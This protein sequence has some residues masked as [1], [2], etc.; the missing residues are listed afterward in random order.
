MPAEDPGLKVQ[1]G[2]PRSALDRNVDFL[3][4]TCKEQTFTGEETK[5]QRNTEADSGAGPRLGPFTHQLPGP[6]QQM[7]EVPYFWYP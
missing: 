2:G 1:E 5:V 3:P 6:S 4:E 7:S